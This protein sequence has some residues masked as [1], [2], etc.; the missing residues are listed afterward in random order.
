MPASG[1]R[2]RGARV[3]PRSC[4]GCQPWL[5]A[6]AASGLVLATQK[7]GGITGRRTDAPS[8]GRQEA[9]ARFRPPQGA[10]RQ[11]DRVPDRARADQDDRREGEGGPP[12]VLGPARRLLPDRQA[13]PAPGRR[14]RDGVPGARRL[15]AARLTG[16]AALPSPALTAAITT[17][18]NVTV[19]SARAKLTS[20]K[21]QRSQASASSSKATTTIAETSAIR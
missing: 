18:A 7:L 20:K 14:C 8:K 21:R 2:S 6:S 11:P 16:H 3:H 19:P 1:P 4:Q 5:R 9:R 17:P 10:L 15:R 13:R 12:A